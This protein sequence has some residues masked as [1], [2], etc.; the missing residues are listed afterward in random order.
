MKRATSIA[1]AFCLIALLSQSASAGYYTGTWDLNSG[2]LNRP[3]AESWGPPEGPG[4]IRSELIEFDRTS[5]T[6]QWHFSGAL[7]N[8]VSGGTHAPQDDQSLWGDYREIDNM[9]AVNAKHHGHSGRLISHLDMTGTDGVFNYEVDERYKKSDSPSWYW[10]GQTKPGHWGGSFNCRPDEVA[11]VPI[12][13][14]ALLLGS[15][16]IT[17][18]GLRRRFQN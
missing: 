11:A 1:L 10:F 16:L 13:G 6:S 15:G 8:R 7:L 3:W 9:N 2:L 12:P 5:E 14:A 4:S 17:I 18:L